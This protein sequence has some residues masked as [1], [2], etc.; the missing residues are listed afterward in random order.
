ME[1]KGTGVLMFTWIMF[2]VF[3][4][5]NIIEG[6]LAIARSSQWISI[7]G[8][9]HRLTVWNVKTWGWILLIWG[10]IELLAA[11]SIGRGAQFGRWLGIIICGLGIIAQ[12]VYLPAAPFWAIL[13]I[14]LYA[15][16]LHGLVVYGGTHEPIGD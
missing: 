13:M 2:V 12:F 11:A 3:G 9:V 8:D 7:F 16:V 10:I 15:W 14:A 4:V 1:K 6:I 5:W